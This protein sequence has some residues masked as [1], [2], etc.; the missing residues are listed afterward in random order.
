MNYT[1]IY[2]KL[3]HKTGKIVDGQVVIKDGEAFSTFSDPSLAKEL[4]KVGKKLL[5]D[6][7][8]N[9]KH[10]AYIKKYPG[11]TKE[12]IIAEIKEEL[13]LAGGEVVVI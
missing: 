7:D 3:Q 9:P 8:F 13:A 11:K 6:V 1:I 4:F 5:E 10:K 12:Q 2:I